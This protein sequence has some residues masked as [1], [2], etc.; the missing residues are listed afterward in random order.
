MGDLS[1]SAQFFSGSHAGVTGIL[2]PQFGDDVVNPVLR[3]GKCL[4]RFFGEV[5]GG[6]DGRFE[7]RGNRPGQRGRVVWHSYSGNAQSETGQKSRFE[8]CGSCRDGDDGRRG[9]VDPA[10]FLAALR[11]GDVA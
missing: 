1:R 3:L 10:I 8:K 7:H 6:A 2:G 11:I 9:L 4:P 5:G